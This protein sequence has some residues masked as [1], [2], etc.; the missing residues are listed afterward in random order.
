MPP[1]NAQ[2]QAKRIA[3]ER[4]AVLFR[5]AE[6]FYREDPAWSSRCVEL[7]RKIAMRQRIR[8]ER[9]FRRRFCHHCHAYLVPGANMRVR[10]YRGKVIA[11]CL[12]CGFQTRYVL[13]RKHERG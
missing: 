3:R 7:A 5:Q 4:I 10:V 8:I 6:R 11:T 12:A 13:R 2:P 1:K 9:E